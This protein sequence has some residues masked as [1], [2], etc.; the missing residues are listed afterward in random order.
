MSRALEGVFLAQLFQALRATV[1]ESGLGTAPGTDVFTAMLDER[2]AELA[3]QRLRGGMGDALY[4]QLSRRLEVLE[5][6][7]TEGAH[8]ESAPAAAPSPR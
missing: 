8:G 5:V 6:P 1:P 7:T 2:L 4:R 3:A